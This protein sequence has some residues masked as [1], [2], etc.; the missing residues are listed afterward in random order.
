MPRVLRSARRRRR[1]PGMLRAAL[2]AL[3]ARSGCP[4]PGPV[5]AVAGP[6]PGP[7]AVAGPG[8]GLV[9]GSRPE[10][11][12]RLRGLAR[13]RGEFVSEEEAAALL[14]E[15]E[16][17]LRRGRYQSDHWD[18]A[19]SGYRETERALGGPAGG[20]LLLRVTPEFPPR[21]P[22]RARAHVLDLQ[23]GGRVGP[24]VDSVKVGVGGGLGGPGGVW[25]V[26]RGFGG[27]WGGPGGGLGGPE[28]VLGG[29]GE[30]WGGSWGGLG[31][32]GGNFGG[33]WVGLG[34]FCGSQVCFWGFP[35]LIFGVPPQFCGCTIAG[36]SVLILG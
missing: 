23:P 18:R 33:P 5:R 25:G 2:G 34:G 8:P 28:G 3:R 16:P 35:A 24:H 12:R 9:R 32:P 6:G 31:G 20:A 30:S 22:P 1:S 26:L 10:L 14:A 36:L 27:V 29:F 19:I 11:L 21:S 17:A 13:V 4:G 15:V 7:V